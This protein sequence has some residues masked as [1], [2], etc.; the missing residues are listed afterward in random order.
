MQVFQYLIEIFADPSTPWQKK[1]IILLSSGHL[2]QETCMQHES[3]IADAG[4]G[5]LPKLLAILAVVVGL[6]AIGAYVVYGSGMWNPPVAH[7]PY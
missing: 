5:A 2:T 6:C 1:R 4:I 7:S 3:H